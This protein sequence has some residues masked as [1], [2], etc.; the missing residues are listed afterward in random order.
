MLNGGLTGATPRVLRPIFGPIFSW[1]LHRNI[2]RIKKH[3]EP[4]YRQRLRE[5]EGNGGK[6]SD[7]KSSEPQDLVQMMLRYAQKE[8]PQE[9]YDLD[10][11]T[12]RLCFANFAAVHQTSILVSN[13]LLNIISS[14]AKFDTISTLRNEIHRVV[15][16]ENHGKWTKYQVAQMVKCDSVARETLRLNS[17]SNRGLFRKVLVD[18]LVTEEGIRLPKGSYISFLGHPL[19]RDPES[20][21]NPLQYDPF[22]FSRVREEAADDEGK[23]G[24][25]NLSFVST[26]PQHLPLGHGNHSC[27]GRFLVDFELKMI[28]AHILAKY[29]LEFPVEY[30]GK[31]PGNVWLAEAYSLPPDARIRVKRRI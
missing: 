12:K 15:G 27:P 8:R 31:R 24:L 30:D 28:I 9:L 22:R 2:E 7:H 5:L 4:L 18:G 17:F 21:E 23:P 3:F 20:F 13:M 26:S 25:T 19:Q 6:D 14:D 16:T 11:M 29:D 10:I 1:N